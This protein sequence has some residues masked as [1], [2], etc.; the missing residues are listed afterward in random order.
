MTTDPG[1]ID[2]TKPRL[3]E[4]LVTLSSAEDI[5]ILATDSMSAAFH[6]LELSEDRNCK[7]INVRLA[8]EW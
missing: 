7:L 5:Y 6:A 8:D 2:L 1:L 4:Y 3:K